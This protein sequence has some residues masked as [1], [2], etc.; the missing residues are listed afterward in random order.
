MRIT[1]L[2]EGNNREKIIAKV[3]EA[4]E[5]TGYKAM[6]EQFRNEPDKRVRIAFFIGDKYA[7]KLGRVKAG[8]FI[9]LAMTIA[10][11]VSNGTKR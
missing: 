9:R 3:V 8:H 11:E 4:I 7:E 5:A 6:A 10:E 2:N 1:D